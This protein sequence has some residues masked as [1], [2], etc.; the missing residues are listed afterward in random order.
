[1]D[2]I[3]HYGVTVAVTAGERMLLLHVK[4]EGDQ[5]QPLYSH[6]G[7]GT[8]LLAPFCSEGKA[9]DHAAHLA[10]FL[11]PFSCNLSSARRTVR[12][13]NDKAPA[14]SEALTR[15]RPSARTALM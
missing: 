5:I 10:G 3:P 1:M 11:M 9:E 7:E 6:T 13:G 2:V 12:V 4:F 14:I 15:V 8:P